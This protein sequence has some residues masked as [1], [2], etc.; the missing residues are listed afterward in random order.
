V[1]V[2]VT[3][4]VVVEV[5]AVVGLGELVGDK[6][7]FVEVC[8]GGFVVVEVEGLAEVVEV[9]IGLVVV[10]VVVG[11]V[12]LLVVIGLVVVLVVVGLAEVVV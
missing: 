6:I 5:V 1:E 10:L 2:V 9:V 4:R 12:V 8:G 11:L 3:P 7:G